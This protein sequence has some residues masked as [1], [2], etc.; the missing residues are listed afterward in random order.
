MLDKVACYLLPGEVKIISPDRADSRHRY[1]L[2][3][4]RDGSGYKHLEAG[5]FPT[6]RRDFYGIYWESCPSKVIFG[7]NLYEVGPK[8][9]ETF[10]YKS[11]EQLAY[12]G[13]FVEPEVL[14][15]HRL[16]RMDVNKIALLPLASDF[17]Q[18]LMESSKKISRFNKAVTYYPE[19]GFC[20][21]NMLKHR[22]L[23]LYDKRQE[24]LKQEYLP[25]DLRNILEEGS[26]SVVNVEYQIKKSAEI[27]REFRTQH[28]A[29]EN[30]LANAFNPEIARTILTNRLSQ[31]LDGI[32]LVESDFN[33]LI[34]EREVFCQKNGIHGLQSVSLRC[35]LLLMLQNLGPDLTFT[36]LKKHS[37]AKTALRYW[38]ELQEGY[39][40][41][42]ETEKI[43]KEIL[44][45][46]VL[47]MSP[48]QWED[49]QKISYETS[50]KLTPKCVGNTTVN[51]GLQAGGFDDAAFS[52]C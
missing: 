11:V 12:A 13:V 8:D 50:W 41:T 20:C 33:T 46:S 17:Y 16:F 23:I 6:I 22:K 30:T 1:L 9:L 21:V 35:W 44:L 29:F 45:S 19:D 37:D 15:Q 52:K 26:F 47:Q 3:P 32:V 36:W 4:H 14:I 42:S 51:M 43:F 31:I 2:A 48:I 28:L 40:S 27:E 49:Y 10:V 38:K 18:H 24:G 25:S 34:K 7:H 39:V 5:Y